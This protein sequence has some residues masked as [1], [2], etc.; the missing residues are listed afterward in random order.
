MNNKENVKKLRKIIKKYLWEFY[1]ETSNHCYDITLLTKYILDRTN[2]IDFN[3][4]VEKE[5]D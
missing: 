5:S 4:K 3:V 2:N 1:G